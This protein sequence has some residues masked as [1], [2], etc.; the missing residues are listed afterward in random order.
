MKNQKVKLSEITRAS[1]KNID[2]ITEEVEDTRL[3]VSGLTS[4]VHRQLCICDAL[5]K[6][7]QQV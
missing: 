4:Q 5:M 3:A 7:I 2:K 6:D 1:D